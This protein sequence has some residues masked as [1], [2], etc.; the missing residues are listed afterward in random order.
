[1]EGSDLLATARRVGLRAQTC[2]ALAGMTTVCL[3]AVLAC[4]PGLALADGGASIATATPIVVGQEMSGDS[5]NGGGGITL[6][7]SWWALSVT[8]GDQVTI[9]ASSATSFS[10]KLWTYRVGATDDNY[11]TN[12][13]ARGIVSRYDRQVL[14]FTAPQTGVMPLAIEGHRSS[15]GPYHFTVQITPPPPHVANPRA[16]ISST[17]RIRTIW[18]LERDCTSQVSQVWLNGFLVDTFTRPEACTA[19]PIKPDGSLAYLG[20]RWGDLNGPVLRRFLRLRAAGARVKLKL[21]VTTTDAFGQ[22]SP[23][24]WRFIVPIGGSVWTLPS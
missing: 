4:H 3:L 24:T 13:F 6:R 15:M 9:H 17:G 20:V 16:F 18:Q 5:N 23:Q 22:V 7:R 14:K 1:M 19:S 21:S 12:G 2:I 11:P 8:A 10:Q